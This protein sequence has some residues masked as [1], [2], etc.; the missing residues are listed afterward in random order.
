MANL[1]AKYAAASFH[2]LEWITTSKKIQLIVQKTWR[3]YSEKTNNKLSK[4]P[5]TII[6]KDSS[7]NGMSA[8]GLEKLNEVLKNADQYSVSDK[9]SSSPHETRR[10]CKSISMLEKNIGQNQR[11]FMSHTIKKL[12]KLGAV[13]HHESA[14]RASPALPVTKRGSDELR[15]TDFL[16]ETQNQK[17]FNPTNCATYRIRI[18]KRFRKKELQMSTSVKYICK[19]VCV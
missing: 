17:L 5:S 3:Q 2:V 9:G 10:R 7:D 15:F 4:I 16:H 11:S 12:E 19:R 8:T 6:L 1:W 18:T 14:K 13:Y